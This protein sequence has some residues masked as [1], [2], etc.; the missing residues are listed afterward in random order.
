LSV[1]EDFCKRVEQSILHLSFVEIL[2]SSELFLFGI[3]NYFSAKHFEDSLICSLLFEE[4]GISIFATV[5]L[6]FEQFLLGREV[7]E[8]KIGEI[9]FEVFQIA[10][11]KVDFLLI[12]LTNRHQI[13]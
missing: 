13:F 4:L 10:N 7:F 3:L 9:V 12:V 2:S 11:D 8:A 1:F 6:S 5:S